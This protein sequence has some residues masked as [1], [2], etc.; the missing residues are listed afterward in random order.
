VTFSRAEHLTGMPRKRC[1]IDRHEHQ[2][3]LRAGHQQRRIV[4]AK[5]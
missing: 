5:P 3:G 2:T 1:P 4:Q